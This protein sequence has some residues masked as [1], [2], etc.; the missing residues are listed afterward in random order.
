MGDGSAAAQAGV[1]EADRR[2]G[3]VRRQ[4][5]EKLGKRGVLSALGGPT[6]GLNPPKAVRP[7]LVQPHRGPPPQRA[8]TSADRHLIRAA[9]SDLSMFVIF[10]ASFYVGKTVGM[11]HQTCSDALDKLHAQFESFLTLPSRQDMQIEL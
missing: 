2:A 9:T 7:A 3:P 11:V 5:D 1:W 8:V 6:F 10:D 4:E